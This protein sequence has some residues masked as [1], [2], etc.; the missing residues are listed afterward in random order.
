MPRRS[1]PAPSEL[2]LG[3]IVAGYNRAAQKYQQVQPSHIWTEVCVDCLRR[4]NGFTEMFAWDNGSQNRNRINTIREV[5][6]AGQ[7]PG[8][9]VARDAR[10]RLLVERASEV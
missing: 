9:R 10:G 6:E 5:I 1:K 7:V 8:L 3:A 4:H 2:F